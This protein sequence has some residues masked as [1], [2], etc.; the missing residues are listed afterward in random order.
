MLVEKNFI[1]VENVVEDALD[2]DC[3]FGVSFITKYDNAVIILK[4]LLRYGDD[5]MPFFI[6]VSDPSWDGYDKEF[7]I[8]F[9][10][11]S[12]VFCERFCRDGRYITPDDGVIF[13]LPDCSDECLSH[14]YKYKDCFY[15]KA[16]IDDDIEPCDC[17]QEDD[18]YEKFIKD[19]DG[20]IIG[21]AR[22]SKV[23]NLCCSI[24]SM[25]DD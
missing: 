1:D 10:N 18:G 16:C 24:I 5:A 2:V 13:I 23:G 21:Y 19:D 12:E 15:V 4:E 9:N 6:D 8:S 25:F 7:I 17:C 3:E 20:N 11:D 14:L 22:V